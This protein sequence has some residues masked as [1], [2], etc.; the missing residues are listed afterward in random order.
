MRAAYKIST[1]APLDM[2]YRRLQ[3]NSAEDLDTTTVMLRKSLLI[4]T[5]GIWTVR[6]AKK[7]V[8]V[9]TLTTPKIHTDTPPIQPQFS[10]PK[11][12]MQDRQDSHVGQT[13]CWL[14]IIIL[15]CSKA[16]TCN[17]VYT[18]LEK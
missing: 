3:W 14:E 10:F 13:N 4:Y 5:K 17:S 11:K 12:D 16:S 7:L 6:S 18:Q 15:E 2:I 8:Q 9:W 1:E